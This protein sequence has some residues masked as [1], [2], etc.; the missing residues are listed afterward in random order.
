M[1]V[2]CPVGWGRGCSHK[3]DGSPHVRPGSEIKKSELSVDYGINVNMA[4]GKW[5]SLN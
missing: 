2:F 4:M 3:M 1:D 5:G